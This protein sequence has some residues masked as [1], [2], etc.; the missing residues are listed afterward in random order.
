MTNEAKRSEE[1]GSTVGLGI[2]GTLT[3]PFTMEKQTP[4]AYRLAKKVDGT[5]VLQGAYM[6]QE[7][8]NNYGHDWR[9]IPT[10]DL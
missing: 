2:T 8:C 1:S 9:D 10:V 3:G 4:D 6:W 5:L 7:G